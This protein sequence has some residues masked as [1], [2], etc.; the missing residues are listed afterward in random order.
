MGGLGNAAAL[1]SVGPLIGIV[2]IVVF[3]PETRGKSLEELSP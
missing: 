3:A 1:F 2:L